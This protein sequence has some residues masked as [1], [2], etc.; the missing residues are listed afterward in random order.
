MAPRQTSSCCATLGKML[1]L[2]GRLPPPPPS[3]RAVGPRGRRKA[4]CLSHS[5]SSCPLLTSG[6]VVSTPS[7]QLRSLPKSPVP[8]PVPALSCSSRSSAL[9][10]P[11]GEAGCSSLAAPQHATQT[12]VSTGIAYCNHPHL[13]A[14]YQ[15]K[16]SPRLEKALEKLVSK[17]RDLSQG[18][19]RPERVT[20]AEPRS[21]RQQA[22]HVEW[23]SAEREKPTRAPCLL[24]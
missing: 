19:L 24:S 9:L 4:L 1:Q 12:S 21:G 8:W 20:R 16:D 3:R 17:G 23:P 13:F 10:A 14:P 7:L 11:L 22:V 5:R 6:H 18:L 15:G 2:T